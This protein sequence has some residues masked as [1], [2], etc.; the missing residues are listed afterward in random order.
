MKTGSKFIQKGVSELMIWKMKNESAK[1]ENEMTKMSDMIQLVY[2]GEQEEE[3]VVIDGIMR[4]MGE[5][6]G[7]DKMEGLL[8]GME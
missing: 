4:V 2:Y 6:Y 3:K 1:T 8:E 5:I 7:G